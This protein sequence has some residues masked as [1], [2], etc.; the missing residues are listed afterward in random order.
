MLNC[1][2]ILVDI[3]TLIW[4]DFM[5]K[6][7]VCVLILWC[8]ICRWVQLPSIKGLQPNARL[9]IQMRQIFGIKG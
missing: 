8:Y 5:L 2:L 3:E 9:L 4:L 7:N 1:F 6:C